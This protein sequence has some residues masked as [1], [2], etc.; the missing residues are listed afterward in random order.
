M[1]LAFPDSKDFWTGVMLVAT[2]AA[3]IL[4]ARDYAFGTTLR[5]GPGYF[6][7]ALGAIII[8]FGVYLVVKGMRGGEKIEGGVSIRALVVVPLALVV[9]G[10]LIER[11]GFVPALAILIFMAAAA[12]P[13]F[14]L[15]EILLFTVVLTALCVVVFVWG[16]GLP[17]QLIA[18]F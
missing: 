1:K 13:Q 10:F 15:V 2:G 16:L 9:F 17:Y 14:R 11:A 8:V 7:T 6:P 18:D 4:I 3:A 5:M 12:G